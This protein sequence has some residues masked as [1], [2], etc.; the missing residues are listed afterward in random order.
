MLHQIFLNVCLPLLVMMG[1]GWGLDR[2]FSIDLNSLVKLNIYCFV[3]AFIFHRLASSEL[4]GETAIRVVAF[5][6]CV[7]ASMALGSWLIAKLCG[8]RR[9]QRTAMQLSTMFYNSGNWGLP[10]LTL[11]YPTMG[12]VLQVFVLATMNI[13]T[14]TLGLAL[15]SADSQKGRGWRRFL[16]MLRQPSIYA[17]ILGVLVRKFEI[18]VQ[19][20]V[21]IW[22]PLSYISAGLVGFALMTL[23][24]QLSKT[25]PP[26]L[27][28]PISGALVL[29]LIGGPVIA[30]GLTLL[31]GF[32]GEMAA[33]LIV[34]A[35]SPTAVNTALLAHEFGADSR[36]AAA[37]VFYSTLFAALIVTLLL[38]LLQW[39][40]VPWA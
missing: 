8:Y 11:A 22:K 29:R 40:V 38:A 2:K 36:F 21:F 3:P 28:G 17:I 18:P 30:A 39:G 16:P 10:L 24:V 33:I 27:K 4:A 1:V 26:S 19:E 25:K 6:V 35:A 32:R 5:T 13:S 14:F 9:E 34:G 20:V 37:V 23:G 31:F 7:I 12:P 15:A